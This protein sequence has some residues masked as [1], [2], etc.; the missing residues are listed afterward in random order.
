MLDGINKFSEIL[1]RYNIPDYPVTLIDTYAFPGFFSK[2]RYYNGLWESLSDKEKNFIIN[3]TLAS[4]Q[5][6]DPVR[7]NDISCGGK[8]TEDLKQFLNYDKSI[9]LQMAEEIDEIS[10]GFL[11]DKIFLAYNNEID[12][13]WKIINCFDLTG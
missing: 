5:V 7:G 8:V 10:D 13:R 4:V 2:D 9:K 6:I 3:N 11:A 1:N 12:L